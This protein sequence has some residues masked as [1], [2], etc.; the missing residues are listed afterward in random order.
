MREAFLLSAYGVNDACV[1]RKAKADYRPG[2]VFTGAV[3]LTWDTLA[4]AI[5]TEF[6]LTYS[7]TDRF[8]DN[9]L[10]ELLSPETN[11]TAWDAQ[12]SVLQ[13][14]SQTAGCLS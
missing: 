6:C 7:E 8:G 10:I 13:A 5:D 11:V 14:F 9:H 2:E 1:P 3:E 12:F 4:A